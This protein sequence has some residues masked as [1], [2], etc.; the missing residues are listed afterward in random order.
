M[1]ECNKLF[2]ESLKLDRS[3]CTASL[4]YLRAPAP[5]VWLQ[6]WNSL[7]VSVERTVKSGCPRMGGILHTKVAQDE[8]T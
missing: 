3:I 5:L 6:P 2:G 7:F 4:G 1:L 8:L